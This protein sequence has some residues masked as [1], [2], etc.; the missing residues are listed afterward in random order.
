MCKIAFGFDL[1]NT[2]LLSNEAWIQAY[3]FYSDA[4]LLEYITYAVYRKQSRRRIA[5]LLGVDYESVYQKYCE[6]VTPSHRLIELIYSLKH[7]YPLY[8][9][10]S[11]SYERVIRDLSIWNGKSNFNLILTKETFNKN[12][13]HDWC[14]LMRQ[15][16]IDLLIYIGND[17]EEDVVCC[18]GV[19]TFICGD[20]LDKLNQ[21]N[22][23][24]HRSEV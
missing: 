14:L 22:L 9:I 4:K 16:G 3:L 19:I 17:P 10:S 12:N 21:L 8:L 24:I 7:N 15:Q 13:P 20:F 6:L 11:A 18:P 2:L 1:H 23:L 5:D